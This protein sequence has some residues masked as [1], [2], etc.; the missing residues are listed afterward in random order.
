MQGLGDPDEDM[1]ETGNIVDW[2]QSHDGGAL[3]RGG[4]ATARGGWARSFVGR[5]RSREG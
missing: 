4:E 5:G 2:N 1:G 3:S